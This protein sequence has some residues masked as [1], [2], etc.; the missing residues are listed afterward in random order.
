MNGVKQGCVLSTLLFSTYVSK[1]ESILKV[2]GLSGIQM[3]P[4]DVD[5]F[6]LM[7]IDDICIFSDNV[8]DL[9]RKINTLESYCNDWGLQVNTSKTKIIVFRNGGTLKR[10]EKWKY[11]GEQLETV[12]YYSYLWVLISSRMCWINVLKLYHVRHNSF[13]QR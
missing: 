5:V 3:L 1:L 12:S 4:N 7:Y 11:K 8:L 2:S 6:L 9:Q 13:C 10:S